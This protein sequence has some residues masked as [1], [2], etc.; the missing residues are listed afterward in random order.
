[1]RA[2][3]TNVGYPVRS[4]TLAQDG[5]ASSGGVDGERTVAGATCMMANIYHEALC[6]LRGLMNGT[7]RLNED[8]QPISL[9]SGVDA[10]ATMI[11][12]H[13]VLINVDAGIVGVLGCQQILDACCLVFDFDASSVWVS[14]TPE[15]I[16]WETRFSYLGNF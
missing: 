5:E 6:L 3:K 13:D 8:S 2:T 7:V 14:G 15:G 16:S 1:M 10:V 4:D 12:L 9:T 11:Y